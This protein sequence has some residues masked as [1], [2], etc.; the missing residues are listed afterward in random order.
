MHGFSLAHWATSSK[1]TLGQAPLRQPSL[2]RLVRDTGATLDDTVCSRRG[3][4]SRTAARGPSRC[5]SRSIVRSVTV[6]SS[7]RRRNSP[8]CEHHNL[9][10]CLG[11][12]SRLP[13][14]GNHSPPENVHRTHSPEGYL[15]HSTLIAPLSP[16]PQ[17]WRRT[18]GRFS[19]GVK[20]RT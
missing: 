12:L 11:P 13:F 17:Q 15:T 18:R 1:T 19:F 7:Q 9:P 14:H 10:P 16:P 5:R 2:S 20:R 6:A 8:R 4:L 3:S